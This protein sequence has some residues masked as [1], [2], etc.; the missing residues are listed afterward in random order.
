MSRRTFLAVAGA[1]ATATSVIAT[2]GVQ[3]GV[4]ASAAASFGDNV[5]VVE[6]V[7]PV[8]G[9]TDTYRWKAAIDK[10]REAVPGTY[11]RI[12][13]TKSSYTFTGPLIIDDLHDIEISGLGADK[14][15]FRGDSG[16]AGNSLPAIFTTKEVG[17]SGDAA[18]VTNV[19]FADFSVD[20][21]MLPLDAADV[22]KR[23]RGRPFPEDLSGTLLSAIRIRGA[24]G[25][26]GSGQPVE[27][28][29]VKNVS[30][31]GTRELPI[32]LTGVSGTARIEGSRFERCLDVGF[33]S[34]D[35]VEFVGNTVLWSDDNGV[36]ISRGNSHALCEDNVI[37][38]SF[39]SGVLAGGNVATVEVGPT[40]VTVRRNTIVGASSFGID[41]TLAPQDVL[42]EQNVIRDVSRVGIA[43]CGWILDTGTAS[44][45]FDSTRLPT[46]PLYVV[47]RETSVTPGTKVYHYDRTD[48]NAATYTARRITIQDNSIA[49]SRRGGVVIYYAETVTVR[50]N[51]IFFS[52]ATQPLIPGGRGIHFYG[53][54]NQGTSAAVRNTSTD[55]KILD[56]AIVDTRTAAEFPASLAGYGD[57]V[58]FKDTATPT[59]WQVARNTISGALYPTTP[60]T[61]Q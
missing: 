60:A 11:D 21:G 5:I 42:V 18:P 34:N 6:N 2:S 58:F 51:S 7:T 39:Y 20:G 9:D 8:G 35:H 25:P 48:A 33:V 13:G 32:I 49:D 61:P 15:I 23:I 17:G 22:G 29:T 24:Y 43:V 3:P 38:G 26:N 19:T 4:A 16:S 57:G 10:A 36:S 31:Y 41:L 27:G 44:T 56:N 40:D 45:S 52:P 1:S 12:V 59:A 53:V 37:V 47:K 14:T 46:L 54:S 50:R 28:I 30:V 55:I